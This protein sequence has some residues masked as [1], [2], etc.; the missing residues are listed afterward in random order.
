[1]LAVAEAPTALVALSTTITPNLRR[2]AVL[3]DA[4]RGNAAT[5]HVPIMVGG[6]PFRLSQGIVEQIGANGWAASAAEAV[7]KADELAAAR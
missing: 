6:Y 4:L 3:I 1:M 5:T 2:L 7:R